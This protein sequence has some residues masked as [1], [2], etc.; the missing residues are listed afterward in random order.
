GAGR[1]EF[2]LGALALAQAPGV[3]AAVGGRGGMRCHIVVG[4]DDAVTSLHGQ[5]VGNEGK[6]LDPGIDPMR[7]G[8]RACAA[9]KQHQGQSRC[10]DLHQPP[11]RDW[12]HELH[13]SPA[14]IASACPSWLLKV[15]SASDSRSFSSGTVAQGMNLPSTVWLTIW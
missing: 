3:P 7:P 6:A 1:R 2:D 4:P 11:A 8:M 14:T 10:R 12:C 15:T 9:R 13:F 5:P